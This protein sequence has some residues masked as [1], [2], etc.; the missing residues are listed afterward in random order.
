MAGPQAAILVEP[1]DEDDSLEG[2]QGVDILDEVFTRT[3]AEVRRQHP[4]NFFQLDGRQEHYVATGEF[5]CLQRPVSFTAKRGPNSEAETLQATVARVLTVQNHS[6]TEGDDVWLNLLLA[7]ADFPEF[8]LAPVVPPNQRTYLQ[9]PPEVIWTNTAVKLDSSYQKPSFSDSVTFCSPTPA[10]ATEWQMLFLPGS[11]G[12][13]TIGNGREF[14]HCQFLDSN[15]FPS[16]TAT[17][18]VSGRTYFELLVLS[19]SRWQGLRLLKA[20]GRVKRFIAP[21]PCGIIYGTDLSL[22][23]LSRKGLA[24]QQ[25][26][27]YGRT[28]RRK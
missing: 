20:R 6:E 24:S 9:F 12:T 21:R 22:M 18:D 13:G 3:W 14:Q 4:R 28:V 2:N 26:S 23:L 10:C 19:L 25:F 1:M 5:V 16:L 7:A 11:A 27:I 17:R 15:L 8:P